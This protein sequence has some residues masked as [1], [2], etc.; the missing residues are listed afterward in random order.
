MMTC[1]TQAQ[2]CLRA[3]GRV[4]ARKSCPAQPRHCQLQAPPPAPAA[5]HGGRG[6][7]CRWSTTSWTSWRSSCRCVCCGGAGSAQ[8]Q[9]SRRHTRQPHTRARCRQLGPEGDFF[10]DD[11]DDDEYKAFLTA[12]HDP[13]VRFATGLVPRHALL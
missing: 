5:S 3:A 13:R 6:P 4:K 10:V 12:F 11:A 1:Q 2:G 7:T 9:I 8:C